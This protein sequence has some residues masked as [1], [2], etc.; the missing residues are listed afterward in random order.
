ME[1]L[2]CNNVYHIV[3]IERNNVAIVQY[4]HWV[5]A[6]LYVTRFYY[7][8]NRYMQE[9]NVYIDNCLSNYYY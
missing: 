2:H 7:Q 1:I 5:I 3:I 9:R 6:K 8:C 4:L